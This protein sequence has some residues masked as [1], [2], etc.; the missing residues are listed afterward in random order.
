MVQENGKWYPRNLDGSKH[1]HKTKT[2]AKPTEQVQQELKETGKMLAEAEARVREIAREE[3][4]SWFA[5]ALLIAEAE[6]KKK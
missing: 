6:A 5:R 3:I 1:D 2:E 4:A